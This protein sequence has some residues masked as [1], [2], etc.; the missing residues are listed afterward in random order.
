MVVGTRQDDQQRLSHVVDR[1][2][3]L[4]RGNRRNRRRWAI[5]STG[6]C[7][8]G[9]ATGFRRRLLRTRAAG[10]GLRTAGATATV[11]QLA[12]NGFRAGPHL[13]HVGVKGIA[14]VRIAAARRCRQRVQR[15][16]RRRQV[17][18][19]LGYEILH[20][21]CE[22]AARCERLSRVNQSSTPIGRWHTRP[23]PKMV[24]GQPFSRVQL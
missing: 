2:A 13:P 4:F 9:A 1:L 22:S 5:G 21:K 20:A 24:P 10:T 15:K 23:E 7:F 8:P 6:A 19:Y 3:T 16:Q 12:T 18:Q 14:P 11:A 17:D